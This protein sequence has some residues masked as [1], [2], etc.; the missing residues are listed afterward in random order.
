MIRKNRINPFTRRKISKGAPVEV[1]VGLMGR[2]PLEDAQEMI[3]I[4][5]EC[6]GQIDDDLS[7]RFPD[8]Q[9][10]DFQPAGR[11]LSAK[12]SRSV[13]RQRDDRE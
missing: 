11:A 5:D 9:K 1:I 10:K 3:R 4:I 13:P 2:I 7:I 6:C 8:P 12:N